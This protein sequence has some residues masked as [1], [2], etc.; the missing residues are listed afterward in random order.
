MAA[1]P[2]IL[3]FSGALHLCRVPDQA[4]GSRLLKGFGGAQDMSR[5]AGTHTL[6]PRVITMGSL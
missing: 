4:G 5:A 6:L 3:S 1:L 2:G